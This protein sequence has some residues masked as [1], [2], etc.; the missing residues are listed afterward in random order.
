MGPR[1]VDPAYF[2]AGDV[3]T[4]GQ[5]VNPGDFTT[6]AYLRAGMN[7]N[8]LL[9]INVGASAPLALRQ[10]ISNV[11]RHMPSPDPLRVD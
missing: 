3:P 11:P 4:Y 2:F 7:L 6:L 8:A 10:A 9:A 1:E 5:R